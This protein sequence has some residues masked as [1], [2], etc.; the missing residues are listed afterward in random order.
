LTSDH[1]TEERP[2]SEHVHRCKAEAHHRIEDFG[3][4]CACGAVLHFGGWQMITDVTPKVNPC[5]VILEEEKY[6]YEFDLETYRAD[7][8]RR[9]NSLVELA[10]RTQNPERWARLVNKAAGLWIALEALPRRIQ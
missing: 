3:C 9:H 6:S 4:E 5:A 7:L 1:H 2:V 8:Q 10:E